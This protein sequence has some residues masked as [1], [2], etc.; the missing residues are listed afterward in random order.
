[1]AYEN[2]RL[3]KGNFTIVE[4][5]YWTMDEDID[6][7]IV[8]TDDGTLSFSYPLDT[9]I[10]QTVKSMEYD[11]RNVWTLRAT[12]TD[13]VTID[14]WYIN[15]YV[16]TLRNSFDFVPGPSHKY[17]VD[18]FTVEH[19]HIAFS[20]AESAGQS[21]LSITDGTALDSG[22]TVVLGPNSLGQLEE[23]TVNSATS[24]SVQ[25]NGTTTYAYAED[26]PITFY[27]RLWLFNNYNGTDDSSGA[28]YE[29]DAYTGSVISKTA[30]GAFTDI[31]A[32]TFYGIPRYVFDKS[33]GPS[34]IDPRYNS[35][36][37]VK[38]TNLIFLDPD[39]ISN[40][41]SSMVMDNLNADQVTLIP[42]Y[43]IAIEGSNVYRLQQS[44]T[45]YGSTVSWST[46]NYQL[47]SL[48]SFITSISLRADPAILPA[49]GVNT[50][51]ITAIVKDQFNLPIQSRQVYFTDDD[52][53]GSI[54]SSPVNT[55]ATGTASTVYIAGTTA[56]E[57]RITATAQQA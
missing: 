53:N 57:T 6:S 42:I 40:S 9:T 33:V 56:R 32:C 55:D 36:C 22:Y 30:G 3:R 41:F 43:D 47:S 46:Y 51:S 26:D 27:K 35:I 39:D 45:Y 38:G 1:M 37:Y 54:V 21:I 48:N 14:R 5:Y 2:V 10:S 28:L 8:K 13:Q 25:I 34:I 44:A 4:G 50:S 18:T 20:A 11:G 52:D 15:N 29:V 16:C 17:D 7:L 12:G 19:Y 24:D 31:Q 23:K 49:N